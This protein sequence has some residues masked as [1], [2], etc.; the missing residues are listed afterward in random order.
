M[1]DSVSGFDLT[2]SV[3]RGLFDLR[4]MLEAIQD[5]W[6]R[7]VF[8]DA[9]E[10]TVC[11]LASLLPDSGKLRSNEFFVYRDEDSAQSWNA[12]GKSSP[13]SNSMV[14]F[15]IEDDRL[16]ADRLQLTMVVDEVTPEM[17]ELF[18]AIGSLFPA[19]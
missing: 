4:L 10:D 3:E 7:A 18:T 19:S 12:D 13:N 15:L 16:P 9:N 17:S 5:R 14:H 2:L 6:P 1:N 8:Q 11:S